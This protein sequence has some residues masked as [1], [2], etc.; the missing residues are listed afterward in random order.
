MGRIRRATTRI[1]IKKRRD[2][3]FKTGH[4]WHIPCEKP[5]Q[6]TRPED[7]TRRWIRL[8]DGNIN[9]VTVRGFDGRPMIPDINNRPNDNMRML[10]PKV[11]TT[12]TSSLG[13]TRHGI[14]SASVDES[15]VIN[16][17][18]M[19]AM[20]NELNA[21][22]NSVSPGC[23]SDFS[24]ANI[25]KW[26][27]CC[28]VDI[29][30]NNCEFNSET[31]KLYQEVK[32]TG[33][34][35]KSAVPNKVLQVALQDT[36]IGNHKATYILNMMGIPT[37]CASSM[38]KQ[39]NAVGEETV[40]LNVADMETIR[41]ELKGIQHLRGIDDAGAIN[42]QMDG[43]Y[44][45]KH[46]TSR[47]KMG[48]CATQMVGLCVENVTDQHKIIGVHVANK[49]CW[50]GAYLRAQGFE[51]KCGATG[52]NVDQ[53][54]K[55]CTANFPE[56]EAFKEYDIGY[57]IGASLANQGVHVEHLTTDGD[58]GAHKGMND[59][60][61]KLFGGIF[62]VKHQM[63]SIHLGQAQIRA[64]YKAEFSADM[65]PGVTKDAKNLVKKVFINDLKHRTAQVLKR[66][67]AH[68]N[69]NIDAI[70]D[71]LQKTVAGLVQCYSGDCS[72]C[73]RDNFTLCHGALNQSLWW[74]ASHH[75]S[76][77]GKPTL[78]MTVIDKNLVQILVE[79]FLSKATLQ[80]LKIGITTQRVESVNRAISASD[81][82][83]VRRSRNSAARVHSAVHRVNN[84]LYCSAVKKFKHFG[85]EHSDNSRATK[86]LM[87]LEARKRYNVHYKQSL[88][89]KKS[90]NTMKVIRMRDFYNR[91]KAQRLG[92]Y[93][94][95]VLV[96]IPDVSM[97]TAQ[98][99]QLKK[100][101]R[102]PSHPSKCTDPSS[103]YYDHSYFR[104]SFK[105]KKPQKTLK[106]GG[107]KS[108]RYVL[109]T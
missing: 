92:D 41:E 39:A 2:S 3:M 94:K 49:L 100:M 73:T 107:Y 84:K 78:K 106:Q 34:G 97:K 95:H 53:R 38:T 96:K 90:A 72:E 35:R 109:S 50:R 70:A 42:A 17:G 33:P 88:K 67:F 74:D 98:Q 86:S 57:A 14:G 99:H 77:F 5:T 29:K 19:L 103:R 13:A 52:A 40:K 102:T 1:G 37:P 36:P 28:C 91:K 65:F 44:N 26:G 11:I 51:V 101:S 8:T 45:S 63:D 61:Q 20:I 48:R 54:H 83:D 46:L 104:P 81:P 47:S 76:S 24:Y 16:T 43:R 23:Q 22:H 31:F 85:V 59:A 87:A 89:F 68:F 10:R 32:A 64:S 7:K 66:L 25:D 75:W 62:T 60:V 105:L 56:S 21:K 58:S 15:Y 12:K 79:M 6:E 93:K 55:D 30:C 80:E 9:Q 82:K 71:S 18:S 4:Q 69:G 27:V 108:Q